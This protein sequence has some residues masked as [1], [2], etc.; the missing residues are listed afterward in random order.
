MYLSL[1]FFFFFFFLSLFLSFSLSFFHVLSFFFL[2]FF[3]LVLELWFTYQKRLLVFN[4]TLSEIVFYRNVSIFIRSLGSTFVQACLNPDPCCPQGPTHSG[5]E[6]AQGPVDLLFV[7]YGKRLVGLV[8]KASASR[9]EDP[10]FES[11]LRRNFSGSSHTSDL[12]IGTPVATLPGAW[13][14]RI[15]AETG[16]PGISIQ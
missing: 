10:V 13:H 6:L 8:V 15:S 5:N 1:S 9:A 2:S 16:R 4:L 11:H 12:K 3:V 14:Y 7:R